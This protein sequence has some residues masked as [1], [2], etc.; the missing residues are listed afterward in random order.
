[1]RL[2]IRWLILTAL[3]ACGAASSASPAVAP[4]A[5][6]IEAGRFAT[7]ELAPPSPFPA[8]LPPAEVRP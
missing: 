6:R 7:I 8:R 5:A 1:M 3:A 4:A 2:R